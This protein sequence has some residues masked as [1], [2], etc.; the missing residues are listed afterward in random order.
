MNRSS[1]GQVLSNL[2]LYGKSKGFLAEGFICSVGLR[3]NAS[4]PYSGV[5]D[6]GIGHS[7]Q[8]DRACITGLNT[9]RNIMQWSPEATAGT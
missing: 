8:P 1:P 4:R 9:Q 7:L 3:R 6:T 5:R 2:W